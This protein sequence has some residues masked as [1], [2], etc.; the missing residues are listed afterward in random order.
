LLFL[1]DLKGYDV[2]LGK[3]AA[4]SVTAMYGLVAILPVLALPILLG[5][6][7]AGDLTRV[8]V[9]FLNTLFFSLSA[10]MFV[11]SI[12]RVERKAM[13]GTFLVL[14][15]FLVGPC[16]LTVLLSHA[17]PLAFPPAFGLLPDPVYACFLALSPLPG[18]WGGQ[19]EFWYSTVTIQVI[20]WGFL[21]LA[22]RIAPAVWKDNPPPP[23]PPP[24][25]QTFRSLAPHNPP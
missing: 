7:T 21:A 11:S 8:A 12:S 3:L 16:V 5:G 10:G 9:M 18:V 2:V 19:R 23:Q 6:V 17:F 24:P 14:F 15:L 20:G 1:A 22:S 13:G 25:P 4:T